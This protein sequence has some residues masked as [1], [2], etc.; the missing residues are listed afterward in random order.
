VRRNFLFRKNPGGGGGDVVFV[1][2]L[3]DNLPMQ[4]LSPAKPERKKRRVANARMSQKEI[5]D[6]PPMTVIENQVHFLIY[7]FLSI[8]DSAVDFMI[9]FHTHL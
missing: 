5:G 2:V 8:T 1:I 9:I 4:P 6:S 7:E 3:R